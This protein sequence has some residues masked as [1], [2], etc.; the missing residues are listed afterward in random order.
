MKNQIRIPAA[1]I[2]HIDDW[3][4]KLVGGRAIDRIVYGTIWDLTKRPGD[5]RP[6]SERQR[7]ADAPTQFLKRIAP[8][9][10]GAHFL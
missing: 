4:L 6:V 3:Q 7:S 5:G 10:R 2:V 8:F 1:A 9:Q